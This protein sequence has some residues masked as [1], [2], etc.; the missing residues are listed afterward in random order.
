MLLKVHVAILGLLSRRAGKGGAYWACWSGSFLDCEGSR[1]PS[2]RA[3]FPLSNTVPWPGP[4]LAFKAVFG[5]ICHQ[6]QWWFCCSRFSVLSSRVYFPISLLHGVGVGQKAALWMG[7][8]C[9]YSSKAPCALLC[10]PPWSFP[11]SQH[12]SRRT[13]AV[14]PHPSWESTAE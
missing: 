11:R 8:A 6:G 5:Y 7:S 10:R 2:L 1:S 13:C 3:S 14:S 12:R 4:T 9:R